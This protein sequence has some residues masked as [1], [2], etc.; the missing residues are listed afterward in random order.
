MKFETLPNGVRYRESL[1]SMHG[2]S[3]CL[4]K[5]DTTPEQ[6]EEAKKILFRTRDVYGPIRVKTLKELE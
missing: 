4:I 1:A 5:D 3:F 6:I 2:M